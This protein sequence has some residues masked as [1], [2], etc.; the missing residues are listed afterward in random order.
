MGRWTHSQIFANLFNEM[1]L[2][3]D[4]NDGLVDFI[5]IVE[6]FLD[7]ISIAS[8]DDGLLKLL[9]HRHHHIQVEILR[10]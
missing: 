6:D 1:E 9:S 2:V 3:R 8:I 5:Q 7:P 4:I 10:D